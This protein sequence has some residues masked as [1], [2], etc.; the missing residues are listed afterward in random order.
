MLVIKS[1]D[2]YHRPANNFLPACGE[3]FEAFGKRVVNVIRH[4][5]G[6][7]LS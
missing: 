3:V 5:V 7:V 2:I 6:Q 1:G 4:E